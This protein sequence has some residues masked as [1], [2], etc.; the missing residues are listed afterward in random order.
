M[1]TRKWGREG[2]AG[3]LDHEQYQCLQRW[4]GGGIRRIVIRPFLVVSVCELESETC[5]KQKRAPLI[6]QNEEYTHTKKCILQSE[7]FLIAYL[8]NNGQWEGL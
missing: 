8:A 4:R 6:H 2:G 3:T 7:A 1:K 5:A